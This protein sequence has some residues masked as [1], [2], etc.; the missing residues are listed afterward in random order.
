MKTRIR[1][2]CLSVVGVVLAVGAIA[3]S[4]SPGPTEPTTAAPCMPTTF[5]NPRASEGIM[6][7]VPTKPNLGPHQAAALAA[8]VRRQYS[9]AQMKQWKRFYIF[10]FKDAKTAG[11]FSRYQAKR[12]NMPLQNADYIKLKT[13]WPKTLVRY[14][15]RNQKERVLY[16][17]NNPN[18]WWL[19]R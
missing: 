13:I 10:V 12:K 19:T 16:P 7:L 17:Q 15:Y 1:W 11:A 3:S 4:S 8:F 2:M 14:E 9:K 6:A 18:G 5:P